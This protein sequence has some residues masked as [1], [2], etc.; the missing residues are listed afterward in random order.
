[1]HKLIQAGTEALGQSWKMRPV[2][3]LAV[4]ALSMQAAIA[5]DALN[6]SKTFMVTGDYVVGGV[7]LRGQGVPN[8]ATQAIT[9][10]VDSYASGAPRV[11]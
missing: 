11:T 5:A 9:G 8:P 1:M 3:F 7:G 6:L 2:T 4:L 10:G